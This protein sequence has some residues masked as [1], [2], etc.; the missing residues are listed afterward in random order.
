ML[1]NLDRTDFQLIERFVV[2][3]RASLWEERKR[4]KQ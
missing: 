2:G 1:S 3:T 4:M